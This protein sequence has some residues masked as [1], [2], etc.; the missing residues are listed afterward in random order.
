MQSWK[1]FAMKDFRTEQIGSGHAK[2]AGK[3]ITAHDT[4]LAVILWWTNSPL[5]GETVEL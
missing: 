2:L 4:V 1:V 3:P 5:R